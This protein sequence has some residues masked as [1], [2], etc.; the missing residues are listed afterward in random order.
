[1]P[2]LTEPPDQKFM[3][4]SAFMGWLQKNRP[5]VADLCE[6]RG[7]QSVLVFGGPPATRFGVKFPGTWCY[8]ADEFD[9]SRE[10]DAGLVIVDGNPSTYFGF[11]DRLS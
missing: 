8:D 4:S 9:R 5:K 2:D 11:L 7:I 3:L 1:M 10:T 6:R